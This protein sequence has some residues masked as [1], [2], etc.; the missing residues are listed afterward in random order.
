MAG[1]FLVAVVVAVYFLLT[2]AC[3][4]LDKAHEGNRYGVYGDKSPY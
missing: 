1:L 4:K 3:K 2:K